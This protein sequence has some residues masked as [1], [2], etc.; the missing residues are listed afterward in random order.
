MKTDFGVRTS[1]FKNSNNQLVAITDFAD[2]T[3][4]EM[5]GFSIAFYSNGKKA[6]QSYYRKNVL[7]G[8]RFEW[9]ST[10]LLTDSII[11]QDG[12]AVYGLHNKYAPEGYLALR[13]EKDSLND[14]Y[15]EQ[16]FHADGSIESEVDFADGKGIFKRYQND[17]SIRT[18]SIFTLNKTEAAF[19]GG[20]KAWKSFLERNL[21]AASAMS[22]GAPSGVYVVQIGF[23]VKEDGT[24]TDI[25]PITNFGYG[26]EEETIRVIKKSG[27][28]IP[29]KHFGIQ[30]TSFRNQ[31]MT[32]MLQR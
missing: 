4:T 21:D 5:N 3:L 30:V 27:K 7:E 12:N 24:V 29:A 6:S 17:G 2:S 16:T 23:I 32:F 28:W 9:D 19:P 13:F 14:S 10:R 22:K 31:S 11:Y 15:R 8:K 20:S 26:M 25:K 1:F 18:D